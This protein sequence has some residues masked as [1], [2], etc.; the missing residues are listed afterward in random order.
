MCL[1]KKKSAPTPV[2]TP[3]PTPATFPPYPQEP[4]INGRQAADVPA[5]Q[6]LLATLVKYNVPVAFHGHWV[7][8]I[9]LEV[10]DNLTVPVQDPRFPGYTVLMNVPAYTD[11]T[12]N[13]REDAEYACE[14]ITI[15]ELSH[16]SFGLLLPQ[17]K[18]EFERLYEARKTDEL[19]TRLW[20]YNDYGF[21]NGHIEAHAEIM[22][23]LGP[24]MPAELR[25]YYPKLINP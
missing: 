16:R 15:H 24:E 5:Q 10:L 13:F 19:L 9:P 12:G 11:S 7:D 8:T 23:Y 1:F 6:L 3:E 25:K 18:V 4:R 2:P 20:Q 21:K 22:R 14:G 17:E